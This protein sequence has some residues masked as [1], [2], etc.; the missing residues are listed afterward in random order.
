MAKKKVLNLYK[1]QGVTPLELI[2]RFRQKH[3]EYKDEKLGY[4]GRLDPMAEGILLVLVGDEN[5]KRKTYEDSVAGSA[6]KRGL[7][8]LL[9][10]LAP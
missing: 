1:P 7:P 9:L 8:L 2:D 4:A 10:L 5:K 6:T 3:P